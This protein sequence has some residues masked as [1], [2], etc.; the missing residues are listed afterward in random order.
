MIRFTANSKPYSRSLMLRFLGCG[1]ADADAAA[2]F[3]ECEQELLPRLQYMAVTEMFDI[4]FLNGKINLGFATVESKSLMRNLKDCSKIYLFAA[5]IGMMPDR[6]IK[7]YTAV[8]MAK[9]VVMQAV[10]ASAAECWCEEIDER[11]QKLA[12]DAGFS[13]RPRFSFG[14]GDTPLSLQRRV[15]DALDVEKRL[16]ITLTE[17][18]LMYP[19]KSVTA[20][21]GLYC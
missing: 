17:S 8:S 4:A 20:V 10:G 6:L 5:T 13:T 15:F 1:K 21:I 11:I 19:T 2:L 7:K 12:A 16:G 18:F 9:A 14:Y 3:K